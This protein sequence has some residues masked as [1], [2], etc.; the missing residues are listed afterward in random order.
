MNYHIDCELLPQQADRAA[1]LD[2]LRS[3]NTQ[4]DI[5]GQDLMVALR[6]EDGTLIGGLWGR[7]VSGWLFVESLFVPETARGRGLGARLLA[8][9]E[10]QA[11]LRHCCGVWL[12]TYEFQAANFYVRQGYELFA[13][14]PSE[15]GKGRLFFQK[16]LRAANTSLDTS[17]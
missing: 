5:T 12:Y 9:A 16:F 13:N 6:A 7:N 11:R 2:F 3:F 14:L 1:L 8:A 15:V 10:D 4:Y 17:L